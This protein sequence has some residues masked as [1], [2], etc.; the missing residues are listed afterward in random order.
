MRKSRIFGLTVVSITFL[1]FLWSFALLP[2]PSDILNPVSGRAYYID[3]S[4]GSDQNSGIR[5]HEAWKNCPGMEAY[6][7][8]MTLQP[9]DTVYFDSSDKWIVSGIQGILL[10]GG[11][12]YIGDSWGS[13]I[14]A[15]IIAGTDLASGV[16]RFQDNTTIPTIFKGFNVDANRKVATGIDINHTHSALMNGAAKRVENCD[17]HHVWSRTSLNQY[18]Y[19]IIISNYGGPKGYCENVEILNCRVHDISRDA[20]CLYPSDM[21]GSRIRNITVRG[22]EVYNSGQDPD[23]GAGSGI[24][25]KGY[26]VDAY[27]EYNYIHD[28]KASGLFINSNETR[29]YPGTGPENI[30]LRY[31]IV[32]NNTPHGA[33]KLHDGRS[34]SDP[35][36]VK[37]YGNIIYG[38][39]VN[40][41]LV[42]LRSL[43]N[44]NSIRV[45]NN[46]FYNAPVI[47]DC[48]SASFDVFEF[49][50]NA[51]FY[52][53]GTPIIG[54]DRFTA[55]SNNMTDK[56]VFKNP[57]ELPT[58]FTG[59]YGINLVPNT[60]GLSLPDN[61]PG[62][63]GGVTLADTYKSSINTVLRPEGAGWDIGAYEQ[64][65]S[66]FHGASMQSQIYTTNFDGEE[67]VLSENGKWLH[68]GLDWAMIRKQN[69]IAS[70]TQTG[71]NT[72]IRKYDDSYAHLSGFPPDQ[73]AWGVVYINKPDPACYQ[74][75]EILLR[76]ES[77]AHNTT[78]YECFARCIN[79]S[80]SY[81]Q[82][83]RWDGPLGKF[84][85]LADKSGS[86]YGLMNGDTLR[87]SVI[88]EMITVY[89][90]GVVKA[91]ARDDTHKTGNPGIGMFLETKKGSCTGSNNDY[92]FTSFTARAL[93]A[94]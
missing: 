66:G 63:D 69:G 55:Y 38:D 71:T 37:I 82:I 60:D 5:P 32:G 68:N 90:N 77:S 1:F 44:K 67:E 65:S 26:V 72:G 73:E 56:P 70:G 87:A 28:V 78:G 15:E 19:G 58:G 10:K 34:G 36:D 30:H 81:L 61:S 18:K 52:G 35:K 47:I 4:S 33:I 76:W 22:C 7:G 91:Q 48:P 80:T 53:G 11:V 42:M 83:V 20:I 64:L 54:V 17:I 89:V 21:E 41:G 39:P 62:I 94:K 9:G 29:H 45:Y 16:V 8:P 12:T 23:Y 93:T 13:G 46:T 59:T 40:L 74:E 51:A 86:G 25:I 43:A 75:V 84:T 88:G 50:N 14:R 2:E 3:Q 85:Y 57:S 49:R 92:G 79:D 31:N 24:C 6:S 27:I